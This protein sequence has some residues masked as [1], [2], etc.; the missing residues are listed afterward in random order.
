MET[1]V[2]AAAPSPEPP[3]PSLSAVARIFGVFFSPKPT[4]E[5]IARRPSWA[6]PLILITLFSIVACVVLNQRMNWR[7]Y[8]GQQMEKSSQTSQLSADQKEQRAEVGAKYAPIFTYVFG[9]P[10]PLVFVLLTT[11]VMWGAFALLAG[12]NASF[13]KAFAI[14][15]HASLVSLVSSVIFVVTLLLRE[16]GTVDLENPVATNIAALLPE[17][18]AKWLFTLCK[19]LDIFTIWILILV[20]IGF[21]AASPKKLKGGKAFTIVF[22]VWVVWVIC[23]VGWAFAWS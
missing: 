16:P 2:A 6:A 10:G 4:F 9:V 12:A 15:A 14:I 19:Q 22:T 7:E 1:T 8:I 23:R 20:A 13:G 5:D 11:L 21:A 17:D 3:Q 18:S